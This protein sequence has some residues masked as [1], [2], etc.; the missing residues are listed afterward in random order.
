MWP[1]RLA[2]PVVKARCRRALASSCRGTAPHLRRPLHGQAPE[3]RW[4]SAPPP[5]GGS[6]ARHAEIPGQLTPNGLFARHAMPVKWGMRLAKCKKP[7]T[8]KCVH[9]RWLAEGTITRERSCPMDPFGD[10][11][12]FYGGVEASPLGARFQCVTQLGV[13]AV[14]H[15]IHR[16]SREIRQI[17]MLRAESRR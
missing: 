13:T 12:G 17:L 9:A 1:L 4:P 7:L 6:A 8:W 14:S 11:S 5:A 2:A 15:R 10:H 16:D 3:W